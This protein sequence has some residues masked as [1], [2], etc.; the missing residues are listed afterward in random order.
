MLRTE[1]ASFGARGYWIVGL[2]LACATV[3]AGVG[4]AEDGWQGPYAGLIAGPGI[5]LADRTVHQV[6]PPLDIQNAYSFTEALFGAVGG[7]N[8]QAGRVVF[9]LE[10]AAVWAASPRS[11]VTGE[12]GVMSGAYMDQTWQAEA[13]AR[14]GLDGGAVMPFISGG[15]ALGGFETA[16]FTGSPAVEHDTV[17]VVHLG[18]TA[19]AGVDVRLSEAMR[20]RAEYRYSHFLGGD[21]DFVTPGLYDQTIAYGI[22]ALRGG[23]LVPF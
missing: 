11:V 6:G 9:G 5:V 10:G 8:H 2:A 13:V 1:A 4:Q 14:I 22:H 20:V 17:G 7:Y 3:L 18:V 21:Y 16:S 23:V 15:L 12:P 19:G